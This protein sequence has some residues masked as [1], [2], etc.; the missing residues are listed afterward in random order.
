MTSIANRY[1]FTYMAAKKR[2]K[3]VLKDRAILVRVTET[4]KE[5][6]AKAAEKAGIGLSSWILTVA[7]AAASRNADGDHGS[8]SASSVVP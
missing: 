4:Q 3:A 6:L 2:R 5:T 8:R 1:T 7:L